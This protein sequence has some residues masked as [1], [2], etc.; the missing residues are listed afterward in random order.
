MQEFAGTAGPFS[1]FVAMP[2]EAF[3]YG[4]RVGC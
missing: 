4:L 3:G 1:D 2:Y